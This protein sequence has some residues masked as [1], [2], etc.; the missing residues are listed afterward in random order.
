MLVRDLKAMDMRLISG[1]R[2]EIVM[3]RIKLRRVVS[4]KGADYKANHDDKKGQYAGY[5]VQIC[6]PKRTH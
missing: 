6:T 5:P 4:C 3:K 2:E 1:D